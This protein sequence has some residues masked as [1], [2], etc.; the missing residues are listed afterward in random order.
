MSEK[1]AAEPDEWRRYWP[2]NKGGIT[3]HW[4]PS[5]LQ[6]VPFDKKIRIQLSPDAEALEDGESADVLF[7]ARK[8]CKDRWTGV[9][10]HP[11]LA[12]TKKLFMLVRNM[13]AEDGQVSCARLA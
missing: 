6:K 5:F 3:T 12:G 9:P 7:T 2:P 1:Q 13:L 10:G 8:Q 4:P 11:G